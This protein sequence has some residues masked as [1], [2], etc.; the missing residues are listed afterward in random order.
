MD[1]LHMLAIADSAHAESRTP[2][3]LEYASTVHDPRTQRWMVSLHNN[4][5]WT[6]HAAGRF[7]E[8]LV[9]F[10]QSLNRVRDGRG[11]SPLFPVKEWTDSPPATKGIAL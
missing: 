3:A 9:E 7:T 6:L 10:Q 4:L 2:R 5:G 11:A 8:A 1:A